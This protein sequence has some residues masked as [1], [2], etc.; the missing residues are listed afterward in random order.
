MKVTARELILLVITLGVALFGVTALLSRAKIDEWKAVRREQAEVR[1]EI[2]EDQRLLTTR[3]QWAEKFESL[4]TFLPQFPAE[5]KM[6]VHWLALMDQLAAQHGV[7]ITKRQVGEEKPMGDVVELPI[8]V[9]D[10]EGSLDAITHFLFDLQAQGAMLDVRQI[11]MKP[12]EQK[13]LRGR[14]L[15]Y[16][17]YTRGLGN[18]PGAPAL[19]TPPA[20]GPAVEAVNPGAE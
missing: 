13:V 7:R 19:A 2:A 16:C 17:A 4:K 18:A 9:R 10:W 6:D 14:F 1:D 8:E 3:D 20:A 15:L 5:Q 11:L 12:N